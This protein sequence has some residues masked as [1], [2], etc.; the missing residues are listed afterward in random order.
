[1]SKLLPPFLILHLFLFS[2][3]ILNPILKPISNL[4]SNWILNPNSNPISNTSVRFPLRQSY[5]IKLFDDSL[6]CE[7][8]FEKKSETILNKKWWFRLEFLITQV[9][10]LFE[11]KMDL[12]PTYFEVWYHQWHHLLSNVPKVLGHYQYFQNLLYRNLQNRHF[13]K[14]YLIWALPKYFVKWRPW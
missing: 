3:P 9:F 1:M 11:M 10:N 7:F 12:I 8:I 2:N 6:Q 5:F 14:S 4:I 13:F